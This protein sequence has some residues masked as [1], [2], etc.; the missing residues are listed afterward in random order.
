MCRYAQLVGLL[1]CLPSAVAL[2]DSS[3][4]QVTCLGRYALC[5]SAQCSP[6][7]N[8]KDS[9]RCDCEVPPEGLNIGN[10][11]CQE[12]ARNLTSTFSLWDLTPTRDKKAKRSLG[13]TG[14]N[15]GPWA[16]CLDAPCTIDG[17]RAAC[18]CKL[19]TR[20]DYYT[21]TKDCPTTDAARAET[22]GKIWSG[23]LKAELLSGYSQLW[24]FYAEIPDLAY[25]PR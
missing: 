24:S 18:V 19:M 12:R 6:I 9:V 22:C 2:G 14:D 17:G 21:F 15:A 25:C 23:A 3:G 7:E 20:A 4:G 10:S 8:D 11:T 16:F 1:L 13:C 5:S